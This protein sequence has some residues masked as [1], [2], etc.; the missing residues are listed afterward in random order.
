MQRPWDEHNFQCGEME[1]R[2]ECRENKL[3]GRM[4]EMGL[5]QEVGAR[6]QK[7]RVV[8]PG[9]TYTNWEILQSTNA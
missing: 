3:M 5:E 8:R 4:T 2:P 7:L 9:C 6:S 1:R